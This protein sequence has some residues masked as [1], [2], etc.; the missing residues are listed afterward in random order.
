MTVDQKSVGR[1]MAECQRI[2]DRWSETECAR[3]RKLAETRRLR[4]LRLLESIEKQQAA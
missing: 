1:V 3:R 4:L 2:R